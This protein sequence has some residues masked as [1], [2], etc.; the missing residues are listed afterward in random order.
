MKS[1]GRNSRNRGSAYVVA[2]GGA[3]LRL[4]R[5][6]ALAERHGRAAVGLHPRRLYLPL[7]GG[8]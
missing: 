2:A 8:S 5:F 1:S 3:G 6:E 4:A 7:L